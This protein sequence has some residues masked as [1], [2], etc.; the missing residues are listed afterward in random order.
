[1]SRAPQDSLLARQFTDG[2]D[3]EDT[4][5]LVLHGAAGGR[6]AGQ[7]LA[8][9][10]EGFLANRPVMVSWLMR[11]RNLLVMPLRLRTSPLGCPASSLLSADRS[12][13][14]A[15]RYPVLAQSIDPDGTSAQVLLGADDRHLRFRSCV[16]VQ[17]VGDDAHITLGTRVQ[18]RNRFGRFYIAA[19]DR[20]HRAYIS[21]VMLS[22][23]VDH[24]Q[25]RQQAVEASTVLAF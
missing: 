21:P 1:M 5:L 17:F 19:I 7:L 13:L 3:H 22:M 4:F 12:R 9:V 18:C 23:A 16:G 15:G 2:F 11:V 24:A 10:L 20:V 8:E 25:R 14:Y 6:P